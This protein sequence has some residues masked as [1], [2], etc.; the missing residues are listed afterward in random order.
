M[1]DTVDLID[2]IS[3]LLYEADPAYTMCVENESEDEY[4]SE[5]AYISG[6]I[7]EDSSVS[8][9]RSAIAETFVEFFEDCNIN[10][11]SFEEISVKIKNALSH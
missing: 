1:V 4:Y 9:I 3:K 6:L 8:D 2:V 7:K 10:D 11:S 5:A